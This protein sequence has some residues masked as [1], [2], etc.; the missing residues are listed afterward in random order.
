MPILVIIQMLRSV[1]ISWF[2][3][4]QVVHLDVG[5]A[6]NQDFTRIMT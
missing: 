6:D 5:L 4:M 2:V 1:L 3:L